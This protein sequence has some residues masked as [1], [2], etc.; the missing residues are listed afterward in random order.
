MKGI[1]RLERWTLLAFLVAAAGARLVM[2]G[3]AL[4]EPSWR[5]ST[6]AYMAYRMAQES[7]PDILHPKV[8]YRGGRD[9][10]VS[11]FPLYPFL[12][13][14]VY[15]AM[16]VSESLPAARAVTLLFFLGAAW[17]LYRALA[18]LFDARAGRYAALVFLLLPLGVFYS[19]SAHYDVTLIFFSH[20]F[21]YHGLRFLEGRA[22]RHFAWATL[23]GAVGFMMKAPYCFYFGFPLLAWAWYRREERSWRTLFRLA[24][25]FVLPLLAALA[26]NLHRV[27]V[28]GS[29]PQSLLLAQK[30]TGKSQS[31]W[32]F[33]SLAQR[34]DP[35][36][37]KLIARVALR[38][39]FTPLGALAALWACC[40][41]V[42]REWRRGAW[43]VGAWWVGIGAY[44]MLVFP[45]IGS[46]HDYYSLPL[47]APAAV[48]IGLFL[49]WLARPGAAGDA[50][51]W[52]RMV[53]AVL[54]FAAGSAYLLQ[55]S[56]YYF[57]HDWQRI[58]AGWALRDQTAPEELIIVTSLGR[59]IGETD[60]KILSH[61]KRRGWGV[62]MDKLTPEA[63]D[64]LRR[65]GRA[66][67][68]A[69]LVTPENRLDPEAHP[70]WV[71]F[72]RQ[73]LPLRNP[74]GAGIGTLVL[75]DL[76][77]ATP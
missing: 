60:P 62:A 12:V 35:Q 55:Q 25:L 15:K 8:V 37:W 72:P 36:R 47:L 20:A 16:G 2:L 21:F 67:R 5:P 42:P 44:V 17:Y 64:L 75:Y 43:C 31:D 29:E 24:A 59:G 57:R 27:A 66:T 38:F 9:V 28:E 23:A 10:R 7:P 63:F 22:W 11:E 51:G 68:L 71:P 19:R 73:E 69:V 74:T 1:D 26:F 4:D 65:E 14:L 30:W 52:A 61:A 33:G 46:L 3:G 34:A 58:A 77:P 53:I 50:R 70:E 13:A 56:D 76:R 45:M 6:T 54:G 49:A 39:V 18:L 40:V 32:F 48:M 41:P